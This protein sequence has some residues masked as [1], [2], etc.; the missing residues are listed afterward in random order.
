MQTRS[1]TPVI[2]ASGSGIYRGTALDWGKVTLPYDVCYDADAYT[3]RLNKYLGFQDLIVMSAAVGNL[4]PP[5]R[6][7][8]SGGVINGARSYKAD[9]TLISTYG[10]GSF[11]MPVFGDY[12]T[13]YR[14]WAQGAYGGLLGSKSNQYYVKATGG[15]CIEDGSVINGCITITTNNY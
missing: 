15:L 3:E 13:T 9:G 4:P 7:R 12:I 6:N 2:S 10:Y 5:L 11:Y 1:F 8:V 14:V